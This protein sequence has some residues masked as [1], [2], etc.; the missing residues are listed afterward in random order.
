MPESSS[1][2]FIPKRS[3]GKKMVTARRGNFV[4]LSIISYAMFVSA[5]L[6]SLAIFIYERHTQNQFDR[7][8]V[9]LD[10]AVQ[11]FN[12]EDLKRVLAFDQ[13]LELSKEL[14]QTHVSITALLSD[15]ESAT[16]E[17]VKFNNL[18]IVRAD[19]DTLKVTAS[20]VTSAFDGALF[21][22]STY[23]AKTV[24]KNPLFTGTAVVLPTVT[25]TDATTSSDSSGEKTVTFKAS[26]DFA[27]ADVLYK[28]TVG[29]DSAGLPTPAE[30]VSA[31]QSTTTDITNNASSTSI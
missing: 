22:R 25:E 30:A 27:S 10:E 4:V 12:E 15:I 6:A 19:A 29:T 13:R 21:Q 9:A 16:A 8:A 20:L 1:S 28:P 31:V 7:A 3:P 18:N 23:A 24:I 5:P 14:L 11:N 17:T 2:S 26:F